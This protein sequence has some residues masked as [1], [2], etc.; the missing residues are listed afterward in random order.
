MCEPITIG[1]LTTTAI[2]SGSTFA[3]GFGGAAALAVAGI[4]MGIAGTAQSVIAQRE[5]GKYQNKVAKNNAQI[6]E[7]QAGVRMEQ[8]LEEKRKLGF[9]VARARGQGLTSFA[10][11]GV[12]LGTGSVMD[13]DADLSQTAQ[14]DYDTIDYNAALD[15]WGLGNQAQNYRAEG[16]MA[17]YAGNQQATATMFSGAGNAMTQG[18]LTAK[19]FSCGGAAGAPA[20]TDMRAWQNTSGKMTA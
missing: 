10:A 19:T 17:E 9:D 11:G 1:I 18:A 5:A 3:A 14:M 8:S 15:I 20:S 6:A 12:R 16:K 7:M 4:G 13:W 2:A